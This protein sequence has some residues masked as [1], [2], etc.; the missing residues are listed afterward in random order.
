VIYLQ[1]WDRDFQ[2][3]QLKS[4]LLNQWKGDFT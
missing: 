1:W 3:N 4:L 2:V